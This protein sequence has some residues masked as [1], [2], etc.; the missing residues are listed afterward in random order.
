MRARH[1]ASLTRVRAP[2]TPRLRH[3]AGG[4]IRAVGMCIGIA[5]R[6]S[7]R[8]LDHDSLQAAELLG[9]QASLRAL[10]RTQLTA[11]ASLK[12]V[13]DVKYVWG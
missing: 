9:G 4:S 2:A 11:D 10:V 8:F 12:P 3:R 6:Y 13:A 1:P 7:N 5:E